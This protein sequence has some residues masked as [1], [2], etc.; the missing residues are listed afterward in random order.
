M[1]IGIIGCGAIGTSVLKH[2]FLNFRNHLQIYIYDNNFQ[3][4]NEIKKEYPEVRIKRSLNSIVKE[5]NFL[6]E[7]ASIKCVH[8]LL[9][10]LNKYPRDVLFMSVGGLLGKD[11]ILT[12]LRQKGKK[13]IIPSGAIAGIDGIKALA[14]L[15]IKKLVLKTFKPREVLK[16]APYIRK[17]Q[18]KIKK[19]NSPQL[20]FKGNVKEAVKAFPKSINV[21][22]T[23]LIYSR[24]KEFEVQIYASNDRERI[25][26]IIEMISDISQLTITCHNFPSS[27]N[28][29]TS[30]LAIASAC[31]EVKNYIEESLNI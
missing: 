31:M 22:A 10:V 15:G 8:Q 13:I 18:I 3:K 2:I 30:S 1:K 9:P 23:L 11:K 4:M 25:T 14:G 28:P 29:R 7:S 16:D 5:C 19:S 17:N 26:H 24:L 12:A 21:S 27:E 20:V 6:I